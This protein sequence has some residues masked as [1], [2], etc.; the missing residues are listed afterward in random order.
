MGSHGLTH[1][2]DMQCKYMYPTLHIPMAMSSVYVYSCS[3]FSVVR[4]LYTVD[5]I[6]VHIHV[7]VCW[8]SAVDTSHTQAIAGYE[9]WMITGNVQWA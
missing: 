9:Q 7:H 3:D 8:A 6:H 1:G 5:H 2:R 4:C